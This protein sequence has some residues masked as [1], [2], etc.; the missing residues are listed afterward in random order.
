MSELSR[1]IK[2]VQGLPSYPS[3]VMDVVL[4]GAHD[5]ASDIDKG[6]CTT[7]DITFSLCRYSLWVCGAIVKWLFATLPF[8]YA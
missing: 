4:D 8:A 1:V 3:N 7:I 6:V 5:F 2:S